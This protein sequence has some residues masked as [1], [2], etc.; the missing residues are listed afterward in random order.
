MRSRASTLSRSPSTALSNLPTLGDTGNL[1]GRLSALSGTSGAS[2]SRAHSPATS[3]TSTPSR[4]HQSLDWRDTPTSSSRLRFARPPIPEVAR[5]ATGIMNGSNSSPAGSRKLLASPVTP[6]GIVAARTAVYSASSS[7]DRQGRHTPPPHRWQAR[8][9][10]PG[11]A[12]S[13]RSRIPV[14][15]SIDPDAFADFGRIE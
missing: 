2:G 8:P 6:T 14:R 3:T 15:R 12:G 11:S 10:S 4:R 9:Q 13:G 1:S 5:T 7:P